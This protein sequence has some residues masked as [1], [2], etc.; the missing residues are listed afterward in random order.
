MRIWGRAV[1]VLAATYVLVI[2]PGIKPHE[3]AA[4]VTFMAAHLVAAEI[5]GLGPTAGVARPI[6]PSPV[7]IRSGAREAAG[8]WWRVRTA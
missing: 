7:P 4:S 6:R 3:W 8:S 5:I 2:V 1:R